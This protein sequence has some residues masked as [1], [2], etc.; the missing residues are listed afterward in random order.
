MFVA[1]I[2]MTIIWGEGSAAQRRRVGESR[3]AVC[4]QFQLAG[5]VCKGIWCPGPPAYSTCDL[6]E[7]NEPVQ[8]TAKPDSRIAKQGSS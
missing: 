1:R 7:S 4:V 2:S 6:L 3:G 8:A 5:G